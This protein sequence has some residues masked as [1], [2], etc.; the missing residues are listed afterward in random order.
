[1]TPRRRSAKHHP[2]AV[3][4]TPRRSAAD[5]FPCLAASSCTA[6]KCGC[7]EGT[8]QRSWR[9]RV[10]LKLTVMWTA[11]LVTMLLLP[12]MMMTVDG[13]AYGNDGL[14]CTRRGQ[15][16][17]IGLPWLFAVTATATAGAAT[18]R[19]LTRWRRPAFLCWAAGLPLLW[20]VMLVVVSAR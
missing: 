8:S 5:V 11:T 1:M 19:T 15:H 7:P 3:Y 12:Q 16:L 6:P 10:V 17:G 9:L 14:L 20:V 4:R 18:T 13:C 2:S